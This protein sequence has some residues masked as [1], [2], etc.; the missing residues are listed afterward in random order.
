ML[1]Q[2]R[3]IGKNALVTIRVRVDTRAQLAVVTLYGPGL[4]Q[5]R[6]ITVSH[7]GV[8]LIRQP[9]LAPAGCRG[10]VVARVYV[11]ATGNGR[12]MTRA[13][14]FTVGCAPAR[15]STARKPVRP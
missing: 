14:T 12:A 3:T 11:T 6:W 10:R 5:Q 13:T 4:A 9:A 7:G 2:P 8:S 15:L 1:A